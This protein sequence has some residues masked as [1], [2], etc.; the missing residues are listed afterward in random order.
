MSTIS[1]RAILLALILAA[2]LPLPR[3]YAQDASAA[4]IELQGQ[5]QQL[6]PPV[7]LHAGLVV[8]ELTH[9]GRA[10][11]ITTLLDSTGGRVQG[12][13]NVIGPFNGSTA[14]GIR[15]DGDYSINVQ[16]DGAWTIRLRQPAAVAET[17]A[18]SFSGVGQ[19]ATP[20][21]AL[22]PGLRRFTLSHSGAE[23][24]IVVLLDAQGRRVNGLVNEIGAFNGSKGVQIRQDGVYVLNV[25]A[26]GP[27]TITI[28]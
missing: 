20:M 1:R 19:T 26:D 23:N 25:Q 3:S 24:F 28:E 16:A 7:P 13:T 8:A 21:F 15:T 2:A 14:F 10:N 9:N 6:T 4:P 27:W 12:M 17:D 5:G 22:A 18:T 11:F